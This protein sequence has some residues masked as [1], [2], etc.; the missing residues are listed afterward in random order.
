MWDRS[1]SWDGL[2]RICQIYLRN[3]CHW[4]L[5]IGEEFLLETERFV[6]ELLHPSNL[7]AKSIGGKPASAITIL[8]C[9]ENLIKGKLPT[10]ETIL[11]VVHA[12][13]KYVS[14]EC[15]F[16]EVENRNNTALLNR[17]EYSI[18]WVRKLRRTLG[19]FGEPY[20]FE[21]SE[22]SWYWSKSFKCY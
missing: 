5:D 18:R 7:V 1:V 22:W 4:S 11:Q 19:I 13:N 2:T 17:V 9:A 10:A 15:F 21:S 14:D 8:Q 6:D 3:F 12:L 20:N 16:V